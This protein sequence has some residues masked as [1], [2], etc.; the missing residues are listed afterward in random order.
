MATSTETKRKKRLGRKPRNYFKRWTSNEDQTLIEL[1][2]SGKNTRQIAR[3]LG[4]S[5]PSVWG[6]KQTLGIEGRIASSKRGGKTTESPAAPAPAPRE[7]VSL[8]A[9]VQGLKDFGRKSGLK[10]TVSFEND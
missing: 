5:G 4:R 3:E 8:E 6:R 10:V 1:V 2:Q 7:T 9:L